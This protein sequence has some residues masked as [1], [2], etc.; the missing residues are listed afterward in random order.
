MVS[1]KE[2]M[3]HYIAAKFILGEEVNVSI[4]ANDAQIDCLYELLNV[5]KS[6]KETL[7]EQRDFDKIK[8]LVKQ[9][10]KLAQKFQSLTGIKW[11]L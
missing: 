2:D 5:S 4:N 10:K 11:R 7:D 8:V 1:K 9:K 6:L 3:L